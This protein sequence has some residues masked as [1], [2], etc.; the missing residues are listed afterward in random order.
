MNIFVL[1]YHASFY[2]D[3]FQMHKKF[4]ISHKFAHQKVRGGLRHS[5]HRHH[6]KYKVIK[7]KEVHSKY[8][9]HVTSVVAIKAQQSTKNKIC[10]DNAM[11]IV[12][13][14]HKKIKFK[15]KKISRLPTGEIKKIIASTIKEYRMR[16]SY[17]FR[18]FNSFML[19]QTIKKRGS[20]REGEEGKK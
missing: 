13:T 15:K 19:R 11:C 20:E 12:C 2:C 18:V 1:R 14:L 10:W 4:I 9:S 16:D 3:K 7:K 17:Q 5:H 6:N 8:F